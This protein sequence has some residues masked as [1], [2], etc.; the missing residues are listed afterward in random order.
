MGL[1]KKGAMIS[2]IWVLLR[3]SDDEV[4]KLGWQ[5]YDET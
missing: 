5:G 3:F 1:E 2:F 4:V